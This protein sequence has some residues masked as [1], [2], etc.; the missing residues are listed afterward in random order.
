MKRFALI[1]HHIAGSGSPA[2]FR[3]A[4]SGRWDYDLVDEADFETAWGR[5]LSDYSAVNITSPFKEK[6]F[7]RVDEADEAARSMG[8]INIAVK[9]PE[10]I[11]GYNSDFLAIR[12][13]LSD[14][15]MG[16][17]SKAV[18]AGYG[19]AGKAAFAAAESLG[20][21]ISVCNRTE[22]AVRSRRMADARTRPL[23]ELPLLAA[24]ADV[25]IYTL[26]VAIGGIKCRRL[27]EANYRTPG[28]QAAATEEYVPGTE[29]LLEQA[30]LGYRLM[31]GET[32]SL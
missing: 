7:G 13:I 31:T 16:A 12:K 26:P 14:R 32:P 20:M 10:G 17:G 8:A 28:M 3:K 1:G 27:V 30:R 9:T 19:G 18:V 23:S 11:K 4:Y 24:E 15:G 6:A 2:L 21:E 5:F 29:W 22:K 25:L